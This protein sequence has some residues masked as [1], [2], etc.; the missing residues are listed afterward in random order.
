MMGDDLQHTILS[1]R[2]IATA[3]GQRQSS[4]TSTDL[5]LPGGAA[6]A[7]SSVPPCWVDGEAVTTASHRGGSR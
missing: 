7:A 2:T 5:S 4:G 6:A 1:S 3:M